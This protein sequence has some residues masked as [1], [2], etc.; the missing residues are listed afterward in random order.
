[1]VPARH[2]PHRDCVDSRG[3]TIT[4]VKLQTRQPLFAIILWPA[5]LSGQPAEFCSR[6]FDLRAVEVVW[7]NFSGW[8]SSMSTC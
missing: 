1:M 4:A 2:R 7:S 8:K 6:R 5:H 3:P